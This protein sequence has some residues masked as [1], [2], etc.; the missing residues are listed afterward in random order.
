MHAYNCTR[1]EVMGYTPYE[2]IMLSWS[3][4]EITCGP[5]LQPTSQGCFFG[6]TLSIRAEPSLSAGGK[7]SLAS[8]NAAKSADRNKICFDQRVKPSNLV[9][10]DRGLFRNVRLRG[11][12]KLEAKWEKDI[13]AVIKRAGDLPV[14]TVKAE[15]DPAGKHRTL[16]RDLLL[17]CGFL[18]EEPELQPAVPVS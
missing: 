7:L 12:H 13:Y 10:G 14:Y 17:P 16:H 8:K 3:L 5:C 4:S 18:P 1:N 9:E 11:R 15:A 6:V 2:L